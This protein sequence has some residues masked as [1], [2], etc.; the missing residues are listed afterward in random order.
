MRCPVENQAGV[1]ARPAPTYGAADIEQPVDRRIGEGVGSRSVATEVGA[2]HKGHR[3][4][5]QRPSPAAPS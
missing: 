3:Q 1:L 5:A 2:P 4:S